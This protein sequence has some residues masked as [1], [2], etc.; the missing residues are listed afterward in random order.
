MKRD[1]TMI[2]AAIV[3]SLLTCCVYEGYKQGFPPLSP[4]LTHPTPLPPVEPTDPV[5]ELDGKGREIDAKLMKQAQNLADWMAQYGRFQHGQTLPGQRENIAWADGSEDWETAY[6]VWEGSPPH[7][8]NRNV[9][10][11]LMGYGKAKSG[12]RTYYVVIYQ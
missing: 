12:I 9:G 2:A 10:G 11:K 4:P 1:I 8:H 3:L 6:K 5:A 7:T